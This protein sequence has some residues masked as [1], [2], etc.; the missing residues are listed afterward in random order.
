MK[1]QYMLYKLESFLSIILTVKSVVCGC[2]MRQNYERFDGIID[3]DLNNETSKRSSR[4]V[5]NCTEND[6]ARV[7]E[8]HVS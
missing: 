8:I 1:Y 3:P 4:L 7:L 6:I 2:V 5:S